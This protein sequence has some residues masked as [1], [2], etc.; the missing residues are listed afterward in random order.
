MPQPESTSDSL[1]KCSLGLVSYCFNIA[2][3]EAARGTTPDI[4]KPLEFLKKLQELGAA[5]AQLALGKTT[6]EEALS[7]HAYL[8]K[9]GLFLE[10]TLALP[11]DDGADL[12]RFTSELKRSKE[13]G[14]WIVRTVLLPGRRYEQFK[15]FRE[16]QQ[17]LRLGWESL[18][19]AEAAARHEGIRLALENHKDQRAE[20]LLVMLREIGS[21]FVGVCLDVGNNI[22]LLEEP[23][24]TAKVL[25]D[26]VLSV[27]F[28]DQDLTE[29]NDGFLLADIP[30]GEGM[31]DLPGILAVLQV[32]APKAR[33]FLELITRDPLHVPILGE[34]YWETLE[35]IPAG[36]MAKVWALVKNRGRK[37][38][39]RVS[40]L[41]AQEQVELELKN[42]RG[43]LH[44]ARTKLH[45]TA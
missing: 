7:I 5:G 2:Q 27:H 33:L 41:P 35:E 31:I 18:R 14:A 43:S 19:R 29:S 24:E 40:D 15:T 37:T 1:S 42:I 32:K 12:E 39:P 9:Y 3:R 4:S 25:G 26:R 38:F 28:K 45:L 10:G 22:A 30:L 20:E 16:Y 8:D 11:K 17:A 23:L 13:C 21:E 36:Q 6:L 34:Q 44:F